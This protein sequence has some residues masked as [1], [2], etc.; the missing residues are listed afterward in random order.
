MRQDVQKQQWR[1][2]RKKEA[3]VFHT[4]TTEA[5]EDSNAVDEHSYC[6]E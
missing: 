5:K 3:S 2:G 4:Q 6:I 1:Y